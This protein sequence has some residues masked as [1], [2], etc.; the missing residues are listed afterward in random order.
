M[1]VLTEGLAQSML[2]VACAYSLC[3]SAHLQEGPA[4]TSA[5]APLPQRLHLLHL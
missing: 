1:A 5:G 2:P 4:Y 3:R